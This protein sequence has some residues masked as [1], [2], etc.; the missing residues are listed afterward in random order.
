[1][2][3]VLSGGGTG[4]HIY[5]ALTIG[6]EVRRLRPGA[7]VLYVGTA[8]GLEAELV[9]KA[10][11]PFATIASRGL[12]RRSLLASLQ[13]VGCS[14]GGV[15]Q[16]LR[17]LRRFQPDV[18]VGTGGYVCGPVLLAA[19]LLGIPTLVQE[20]NAVAGV[21]NRLLARIA[22]GVALGYAEAS[23]QFPARCRL[24]VTGNPIRRQVLEATRLEGLRR[25]GLRTDCRTLLVSGGSRGARSIN[26]AMGDV[27]AALA[28]REDVQV[29]HVTGQN[30]YNDVVEDLRRRGLEHAPRLV[31]RPY[32][33][34]MPEALAAADLA[35]FRAGA[36]GIAELTA[37]GVPAI[38]VPYPYAA[39]NHQEYNARVLER[40]GA[41]QVL[42]D[43]ALA[44]GCL[45]E[46][47]LSLLAA[48][49]QLAAMAEAS[50]KLGRPE[51]ARDIAQWVIRLGKG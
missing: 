31:V 1:M 45:K 16:S 49:Q 21:T 50:R 32:L 7:Q 38:L 23:A 17:L 3:L 47:V 41:A 19:F 9:P 25:L 4:G 46:A 20:Q 28:A 14:L 42:Q 15:W 43:A 10:G 30:E 34:E 51:A 35:V 12:N 18:V 24:E 27:H 5:P 36:L 6:E 8:G 39:E 40:A 13:A 29:L 11:L 48:P 2:K 44:T 22:D 33:H 37:R 26:R